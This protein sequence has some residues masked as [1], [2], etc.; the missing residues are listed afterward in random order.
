MNTNTHITTKLIITEW[1]TILGVF[2]ICF[3]FLFNR[4]ERL[5]EKIEAIAASSDAKFQAQDAKFQA[6]TERSDKLY[7]IIIDMLKKTQ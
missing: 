7:E 2:I 3:L 5:D 1:I 4:I 6:Q